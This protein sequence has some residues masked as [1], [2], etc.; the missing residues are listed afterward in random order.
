MAQWL[1]LSAFT[2]RGQV[3]GRGGPGFD[4]GSGNYGVAKIQKVN[5]SICI[6]T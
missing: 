1:G 3:G 4:P 5:N 6:K 2:P